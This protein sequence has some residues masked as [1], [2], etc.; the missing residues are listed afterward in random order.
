MRLRSALLRTASLALTLAIAAPALHAQY[1]YFGQNQVQFKKFKW[2]VLTT[3]HF[4]VH[5]YPEMAEGARIAARMAERSYGRLSRL[6]NYQFR[7]KKPIVLFASRGDFAQNNVTGDLGEGTGGVTDAA[8]QRN[9]F[10][11][12][13]DLAE[14]EHVLTHEMVHQFQYDV[15]F[16]GRTGGSVAGQQM[17]QGQQ[18]PHWFAEGMAEYLSMGPDHKAT[19]AIMRDAAL[20]GKIPSVEQ[21][22]ER[23][24]QFFPYRYGESFWRYIGGRWGDEVIGEILLAAGTTTL[25]RAFKRH[26]G[27]ELDELGDE[28]KDAVQTQYLPGI[29][30]LERPRKNA[31]PLLNEKKTGGIIPV[32]VAPALSSDGRQ[33]AYIST[34]SL[35]RAEVFLDLYLADA[36]NGK[37]IKR[38]TNSTLNPETEELRYAYSQSAFSPDGKLLAYTAY[39]R[40]KDVI[41]ILD[42]KSKDVVMRL[43]TDLDAMVGPSWSPDGKK[44][45]FS[46]SK[47]GLTNIYMIDADGRN[48]RQLTKGWYAGLMPQW[49]PDGRKVAFVSDRG[50]VTDLNLLRFGKWRVNILDL[51]TLAVETI[52]AQSGKN[53]NPMWGPDGR[54]IAYISDRT[55]ITQIFLYDLDAKEHYQLTRMI[56]GVQSV[57][58]NS[59]AMSWARQADKI[60]FV[61]FDHGDY[62]IWS[63]TNPRQLKGDPY[64]EP[65]AATVAS[66]PINM[67][68][69]DSAAVRAAR[70]AQSVKDLA[71]QGVS[72]RRD[73]SSGRRQSVYR[74]SGGLRPTADLPAGAQNPT[75]V[76]ALLDSASLALPSDSSLKDAVYSPALHPEAVMRPSLGYSQD[77][78]GRGVYG[79]TAILF[80]DLLGNRQLITAASVNGRLDEAN[81]FVQ[82]SSSANRLSYMVGASQT[83]YFIPSNYY[84]L[85]PVGAGQVIEQQALNRYLIRSAWYTGV[86]P[87]NRFNR[88][89]IG[90]SFTNID[91]ASEFISRGIDYNAGYATGYYVDSVKSTGSLNFLKPGVAYVSDNSLFGNTGP[92]YGH[93][94]RAAVDANIGKQGY[95][96]YLAD[97]RRYDALVFSF[98]TLATRVYADVQVG[99]GESFFPR[100]IGIPQYIRG[101]D[102]EN[103][104]STDCVAVQ[105]ANCNAALQL[106]GSRVALFNAELRFPLIRRFDLGFLPISLPPLD[107]L[108]FYDAGMAWSGGQSVTMSKPA[109][110]DLSSQRFPLRSYGYGVRFNLFGLALLRWDYAIPIDSYSKKGYWQWT[111]GP[112]F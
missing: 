36:T 50:G 4:E 17:V 28:W 2:R 111:L 24:D 27:F 43:D 38:L 19:D 70:A 101:Y 79:G 48:L 63:L 49:S 112:S 98:L 46:G 68:A 29:A 65:V 82:Y 59:P 35:M 62:T 25:D 108:F 51:E 107:G 42:I 100:Y 89:E 37:R 12:G 91:I 105:S 110:Y 6:L 23:P 78:Y 77:N 61:Y 26:T 76:A 22:T 5:Y 84:N 102:R 44:L 45:V 94:Y 11:F 7:E 66:A 75:S 54:S 10:F 47:S 95:M 69:A 87:L 93:R 14:V 41:D 67:T 52:P 53:F 109:N 86:Y 71:A 18:F 8:H 15:Q 83:P 97:F 32:Y 106:L 16:K 56:G 31:L 3:E 33:I 21:M 34:G 20:N 58:E 90:A 72:A 81:V 103:Y 9:M 104:L 40:G 1:A 13:Q 92:I 80:G 55:G 73:S 88:F 85:A 60:A 96:E 39:R 74:G 99:Q 30:N 57:T 64:R